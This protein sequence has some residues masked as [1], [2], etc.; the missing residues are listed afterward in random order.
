[1]SVE[2]AA[3]WSDAYSETVLAY[4]NN[5]PNR[6]GGTHLSGFRSALTRTLNNYAQNNELL[7][8]GKVSLTGDDM[9]EG[10]T[11]VLSVKMGDPKFGSQTKDKLV[12]SEVKGF[13][14]QALGEHLSTFLDENPSVAKAIIGKAV[15][16]SRAREA[17]RKARE[18]TRR[19]V[20][21]IQQVCLVNWLIVRNVTLLNV[22]SIL[23]RVIL[24]VVRLT[25]TFS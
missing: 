14:E 6:D 21:S 10:L 1:M 2:L 8:G 18:L 16:A 13:V 4:T 24:R 11:A 23:S 25:S 20:L 3:G 17:A 22:K 5:I 15:E 7:K 9:R 19:K 12:S